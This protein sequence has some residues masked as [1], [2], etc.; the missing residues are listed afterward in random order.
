ML[1]HPTLT[2][3]VGWPLSGKSTIAKKVSHKLG[4]HWVDIDDVRR[5]AVG[6]PN[7]HPNK[8]PELA[9]RDTKEMAGAYRF[10]HDIASWHA[11]QARS[12]I[13]TFTCSRVS[14]QNAIRDVAERFVN[15]RVRVI[16][17]RPTN[18]TKEE[19]QKRLSRGFGEGGYVGGVNSMERYNEVKMRYQRIGL[20]CLTI[21]TSPPNT[22]DACV[23]ATVAHICAD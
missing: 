20:P 7:P 23:N 12:L 2:Y 8:S 16:W 18:D 1:Q 15:M 21:D 22:I 9:D 14:G 5:L 10:V 4:V 11:E 6:L 13:V 3:V 17:C 19:I